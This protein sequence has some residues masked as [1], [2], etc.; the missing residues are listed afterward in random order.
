VSA[1]PTP[2]LSEQNFEAEVEV[3]V[4]HDTNLEEVAD[5][6]SPSEPEMSPPRD[7][8]TG[9]PST[10]L[11]LAPLH[12]MDSVGIDTDSGRSISTRKEDFLWIDTLDDAKGSVE[13]RGSVMV[14]PLSLDVVPWL[15]PSKTPLGNVFFSLIQR[16]SSSRPKEL[17]IFVSW[18]NKG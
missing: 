2:A 8:A 11:M 3:E 5:S 4:E 16:V 15:S 6:G 10:C 14:V 18:H 12:D 9:K 7:P 17:Q 13:I 1:T